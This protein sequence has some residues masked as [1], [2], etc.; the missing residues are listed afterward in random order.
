MLFLV[1]LCPRDECEWICFKPGLLIDECILCF[2]TLD[3][4]TYV[5]CSWSGRAVNSGYAG[6]VYRRPFYAALLR[7]FKD[8]VTIN[9]FML[10]FIFDWFGRLVD[11]SFPDLFVLV[12][13]FLDTVDVTY[14]ILYLSLAFA[15]SISYPPLPDLF[16]W[17]PWFLW[18]WQP[19]AG[20]PNEERL[21]DLILKS[22][23]LSS[24][25]TE[26]LLVGTSFL[27]SYPP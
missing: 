18:V 15:T 3:L 20:S 8:D 23:C 2:D 22:F 6:S 13:K 21:P 25:K 7:V 9:L 16:V 11:D 26:F 12:L 5:W 27:Y 10:A 4:L 1:W 17:S 24:L 14:E 19:L